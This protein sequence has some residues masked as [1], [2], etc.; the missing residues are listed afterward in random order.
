MDTPEHLR[1]T[2]VNKQISDVSRRNTEWILKLRG[3]LQMWMGIL[4]CHNVCKTLLS[5]GGREAGTL[6]VLLCSEPFF[7]YKE[8]FQPYGQMPPLRDPGALAEIV[9][10]FIE[11]IEFSF[12]YI[13]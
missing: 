10:A 2:K 5:F 1:T 4:D 6:I 7:N 11:L 13:Y 3:Y 12:L 8:F 9:K